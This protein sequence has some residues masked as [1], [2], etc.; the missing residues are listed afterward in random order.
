M[1]ILWSNFHN[2]RPTGFAQ[3][4]GTLWWTGTD[5]SIDLFIEIESDFEFILSQAAYDEDDK[6]RKIKETEIDYHDTLFVESFDQ[7]PIINELADEDENMSDAVETHTNDVEEFT[8]L[9][10]KKSTNHKV[11]KGNN[12]DTQKRLTR[13][14]DLKKTE[15]SPLAKLPMLT[16]VNIQNVPKGITI[17]KKTVPASKPIAEAAV[18]L[19][20]DVKSK[21][22]TPVSS[23]ESKPSGS[24]KLAVKVKTETKNVSPKSV[25]AESAKPVEVQK[26]KLTK[27]Q[28]AAM[29]KEGKIAVKDGKVFL[30]NG[31]NK[32]SK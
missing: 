28:V 4:I 19:E 8:L 15:T 12:R 24:Q 29:A 21:K 6:T 7:K 20:A 23:P 22:S 30:R 18:K 17:T 9:S 14:A 11:F 27:A 2:G 10:V 31:S 32:M 1:W 25:A 16:K 13:S 3:S 26:V 5:S